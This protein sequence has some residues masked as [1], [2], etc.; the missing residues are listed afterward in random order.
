[1]LAGT[2]IL[3]T[4]ATGRLG[5]CLAGELARSGSELVLVVRASSPETARERVRAAL[6][7]DVGPPHVT[8]LC[9]DVT[10][11]G[12]GLGARERAR[13]RASVDVVVHAAATTSFSAP[14]EKA[15]SSNVAATQNILAFAERVPGLERIAH[16]S[17]AFVAGKRVGRIRESDL[18]HECG[19][20][21]AYQQ[22]K[23]EAE[24]LVRRY[25]DVLPVAVF[26]PSIVL[27]G[28][29]PGAPQQQ[30]SAFRFA[31]ELIKKGFLP[32][33]PGSG[34]TPVDLVTEGDAARAIAELL[35]QPGD[36]GTYHVAGGDRS[37][38][39]GSIVEPFRDVRYLGVDQF[40][41]EVS[42]WR[43]EKPRFTGLYDELESFIYEL[44]YPKIF[45]TSRTE[46]VLGGPV[47]TEDS[48]ASLLG[49]G[50]AVAERARLGVHGP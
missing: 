1:M 16:V 37:P 5:R 10:E 31:L 26:R 48:L 12:L 34:S 11:P 43:H 9:G 22:S 21:N 6:P 29:D 41:W 19:F 49:E 50:P 24:L 44:A 46:A 35:F 8:A 47:T 20:Q 42:K 7:G 17:T 30:R 14:L 13:L 36:A 38:T 4:G 39:L 45:D 28:I 32:A 27:D 23:Y 25:R 3:L 33:L 2:R 18:E 40:A 15:R